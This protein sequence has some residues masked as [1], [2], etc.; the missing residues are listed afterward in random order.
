MNTRVSV[1]E[2]RKQQILAKMR[3]LQRPIWV[4]NVAATVKDQTAYG[5]A[6]RQLVAD[7]I[8][9]TLPRRK[10]VRAYYRLKK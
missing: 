4:A 1:V 7:G 3:K 8:I 5:R 2:E 10:G 6:F 9:E